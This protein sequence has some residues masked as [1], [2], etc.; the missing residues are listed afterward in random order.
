MHNSALTSLL[1]KN[2]RIQTDFNLYCSAVGLVK[3]VGNSAGNTVPPLSKPAASGGARPLD[4]SPQCPSYRRCGHFAGQ[5]PAAIT[6]EVQRGH[7]L[8]SQG[9]SSCSWPHWE[10]LGEK[11]EA[12]SVLIPQSKACTQ[13]PAENFSQGVPELP[14]PTA[15]PALRCPAPTPRLSHWF[16]TELSGCCL[17]FPWTHLGSEDLRRGLGFRG[18]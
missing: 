18:I 17:F 13:M 4:A 14:K 3:A 15:A 1:R 10:P 8:P 16:G 2:K 12:G 5:G 7:G 9:A 6:S 11:Q